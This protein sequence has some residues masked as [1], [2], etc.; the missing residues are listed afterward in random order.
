MTDRVVLS[1]AGAAVPVPLAE[2]GRSQM[3]AWGLVEDQAWLAAGERGNGLE[4]LY[5]SVADYEHATRGLPADEVPAVVARR[6]IDFSAKL[7]AFA[8]GLV[9]TQLRRVFPLLGGAPV[10]RQTSADLLSALASFTAVPRFWGVAVRKLLQFVREGDARIAAELGSP[11]LR[12]V[13]DLD[14]TGEE[15]AVRR[16]F[17]IEVGNLLATRGD[18][19]AARGLPYAD[20]ER[21]YLVTPAPPDLEANAREV[22]EPFARFRGGLAVP[23]S[24]RRVEQLGGAGEVRVLFPTSSQ[25]LSALSNLTPA[26]RNVEF[27]GRL[28]AP[29]F[30]P[31]LASLRVQ[32]AILRA[33]VYLIAGTEQQLAQVLAAQ[34]R[35]EAGSLGPWLARADGAAPPGATA[36][37]AL[38]QALTTAR[39]LLAL[40]GLRGQLTG[41]GPLE[42]LAQAVAAIARSSGSR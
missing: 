42:P 7:P 29:Q 26:Q 34:L 13:Q 2:L 28:D 14:P 12:A 5:L 9:E 24:E 11:S 8:I 15:R 4:L 20:V 19:E 37:G 1:P 3:G 39:F 33:A 40:C 6:R 30:G 23:F 31:Y 16:R 21:V 35:E 25:F 18:P 17:A 38:E 41:A 22:H 10:D 36:R 27:A 32:Q